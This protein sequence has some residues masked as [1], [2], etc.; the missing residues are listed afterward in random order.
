MELPKITTRWPLESATIWTC[1]LMVVTSGALVVGAG[2]GMGTGVVG[3]RIKGIVMLGNIKDDSGMGV[4][5]VTAGD[6]L[7]FR[8]GSSAGDMVGYNSC[9]AF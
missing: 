6:G 8:I 5:V 9:R 1:S 4:G 3:T 7:V 2:V